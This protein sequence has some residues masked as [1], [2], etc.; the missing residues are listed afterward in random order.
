[1][2]LS[3]DPHI[4]LGE[5]GG[6]VVVFAR[7]RG[8]YVRPVTAYGLD[9]RLE[10]N[11]ELPKLTRLWSFTWAARHPT[12]PLWL[13]QDGTE[14]NGKIYS[15]MSDAD[16]GRWLPGW[17]RRREAMPPKRDPQFELPRSP[18]HLPA[19]W[20]KYVVATDRNGKTV[21]AALKSR[22][23]EASA[24]D[25]DEAESLAAPLATKLEWVFR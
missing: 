16:Y 7:H 12:E 17:R 15:R 10:D 8:K 19:D 14:Q 18:L 9:M 4:R 21:K 2:L 11:P 20:W 1:M 22:P 13:V 23:G 5:N 24:E 3:E 25:V 6:P